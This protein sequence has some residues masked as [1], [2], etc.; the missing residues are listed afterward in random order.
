M[1]SK[2]G[3]ASDVRGPPNCLFLGNTSHL[4]LLVL[5]RSE[6][7]STMTILHVFT[8]SVSISRK[9]KLYQDL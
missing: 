8:E 7:S 5:S 1:L 9:K 2:K 3:N 6:W 4:S